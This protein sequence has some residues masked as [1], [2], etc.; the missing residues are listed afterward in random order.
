[1]FN[2]RYTPL[3]FALLIITLLCA[4]PTA[5]AQSLPVD[6]NWAS[7]PRKQIDLGTL[8]VNQTIENIVLDATGG[9]APYTWSHF[10]GS[11]PAGLNLSS[12]GVISGTPTVTPWSKVASFRIADALG[13]SVDVNFV[14][15]VALVEKPAIYPPGSGTTRVGIFYSKQ[16]QVISGK[17]PYTWSTTATLPAGLTLNATTGLLSVT[18]DSSSVNSTA[19]FRDYNIPI[20][21]TT[22]SN[23]TTT[24]N[25][26]LTVT[27][28][29]EWVTP[30]NLPVQYGPGSGQASGPNCTINLLVSGGKT[31]P[32][33]FRFQASS[34][35][36]GLTL[37]S[38]TGVLAGRPTANGNYSFTVNST[39]ALGS[40]IVRNFALEIIPYTL[41]ISGPQTG[42]GTQYT[43]VAP[44]Q[45]SA[46]GGTA[47]YKYS[48]TSLPPGLSINATT[49][50]ITGSMNGTSGTSNFTVTVT[51]NKS[52]TASVSCVFTVN[53][54]TPL[55]WE[56]DSPL[57]AGQVG[58]LYSTDLPAATGG[59]PAYTY[60]A[61]GLPGGLTFNATT[62]R[63]SGNP[64]VAG[65]FSVNFTVTDNAT[66]KNS[67]TRTIPLTIAPYMTVSGPATATGQQ[68]ISLTPVDFNVDGGNGNY[69]WS[70]VPTPIVPASLTINASTGIISGNLTA[71]PGNYSVRVL[72][73][74]ST[75]RNATA[76]ITITV[77]PRPPLEWVTPVKLPSGKVMDAYSENLSVSGGQ[78]AYKF[79]LKAGSTLPA[80]LV[81]NN[82]TG[83]LTG[84]PTTPGN[85]TFTVNASDS[86]NPVF[87]AERTFEISIA[88]YGMSISGPDSITGAQYSAISPATFTPVGGVAAYSWNATWS[89]NSTALTIN[90]AAG[91]V[92]GN[93]TT[94]TGATTATPGNYTMV[95]KLTD[96]QNQSITKNVTVRIQPLII[97]WVTPT[98]LPDGKELDNYSQTLEVEDGKAPYT[99]SLKTGSTLPAGIS[100]NGTTGV[101]SGKPTADGNYTFTIIAKDSSIPAN[102]S[103]QTF[104]LKV[105]PYGMAI[106]GATSASGQQYTA[107]T[108]VDLNVSGGSE[109]FTWTTA[110]AL[111]ATLTI[112]ASTGIISGNLTAIPGNTTVVVKV[113]DA[114]SRNATANF[115]V[116]IEQRELLVWVTPEELPG[117]KELDSYSE[118]LE[119]EGGKESYKFALKTGST[120]PSGITLNGT[121]GL[122]SGK[123]TADG[124]YS[125][126]IVASDSGNPVMTA[127]RT[128]T[129]KV[130]PY[131]MEI[132]GPAT[133]SGKQYTAL[134]PADFEVSGGAAP[135]T[136]SATPALP[137]GLTMNTTTGLVSGNLTAVPGNY[138]V[139]IKVSDAN[140]RNATANFTVTI[141][142]RPPVVWV[143]PEEL[144]DGKELDNYSQILEVEGGKSPYTFALKTG[145]AL[146]S[147]LTL[148]ATTGLL[149]G[150][151]TVANDYTFTIVASDTGNPVMTAECTFTLEVAPYGMAITGSANASGQQYTALTPA[152]FEVTG[153]TAPFTWSVTP[154]L[155][156]ALSIN[157]S[158]GIV[159]GNL[160]AV[161]GDYPVTIKVSDAN[162]RN[163]TANFIVTITPRDPVVW[164]TPEALPDGKEL[165]AYSQILE[166]EGGKSPYTFALKTGS[167]LPSGLTLNATTGLLSGKPTVAN[168]YTFTIIATDS[169]NPV[170]KEERTFT[171]YITP[172][173][174]EITGPATASGKQYTALTPADLN[175][176]GGT[177]PFTWSTAPAL[178]A[179]L[180]INSSTGIISGNLTAAPGNTTVVV[181]VSDAKSRN[182]TAN[183]TVTITQRDPV[184]WGTPEALP[185]GKELDA[186]SQNLT[187]SGGLAPYKFTLQSGT[188]PGGLTLNA[189]TG[190]LAGTASATSEGNYT[191]TINA[192]DSGN[193]VMSQIR[194]F[195]L[196]IAPYGLSVN[197]SA[198]ISGEQFIAISATTYSATGG[199][200]PYKWSATG[201]PA[202]LSINATTGAVSGN[203]TA[204][205]GNYTAN[206]TVTDNKSQTAS[207]PVVVS[208]LPSQLEWQTPATLPNGKVSFAY[209]QN[210]SVTQGKP[211]YTYVLANGSSL[212][213]GLALNSSTGVI[214]GRP[215]TAGTSNF[216]ITA[217][218]SGTPKNTADRTFSLT[219]DP[220][221]ALVWTINPAPAS[222][223][224]AFA[225]SANLSVASG[226]S[227]NYSYSANASTLPPGLSFNATTRRISGT[228]TASGTFNVSLTVRD[229]FGNA[230]ASATLANSTIQTIPITIEAYGL[231][232]N[233]TDSIVG[234]RYTSI[235]PATFAPVGG[236]A[237]Y[238]WSSNNTTGLTI[239]AT[240]GILSGNLTAEPGNYTLV[241]GLRDGRNQTATKNVAVQIRVNGLTWVTQPPLPAGKVA[242]PYTTN[243]T[244]SGGKPTYTYV[245]K[246]GS[247]LPIGL[248]LNNSTGIISGTP[249]S[250]TVGANASA[251]VVTTLAGSGNAGLTDG[252]GVGASFNRPGSV[253]I[254]ST[255]NLYVTD[256]LNHKIRK[257]SPDGIVTTFA[258]S[259]NAASADGTGTGA[260]FNGPTGIAI[261]SFGNLYISDYQGHKIRK[262]TP[263]GVVT[264]LAG[265]GSVGS[266]DGT[267]LAAS[268]NNPNA[269]AVDNIGNVYVSANNKIR[270]VTPNGVVTTLAGSGSNGSADGIGSAATFN[271]PSGVAVDSAGNVY[272]GD[273]SNNKIRK[274]S[275]A[276]VVTTLAGSGIGGSGDGTGTG[277]S[278]F[279]PYGLA[280]DVSGNIFV[281]DQGNSKIRKITPEGVVTTVAGSGTAGSL[282]GLG[283]N[284]TFNSAN[285]GALDRSGSMYVAEYWG[286]KIRK[287]SPA[288]TFTV[289]ASDSASPT[290]QTAERE[291]TLPIAPYGMSVNGT[292]TISGLQYSA[293][294]P[295]TFNAI[296][297]NATYTW[298]ANSTTPLGLSI[299]ATTGVV[300]GNL[301]AS[302]GNY[303]M[304][305]SVSDGLNQKASANVTVSVLKLPFDWVTQP[306]LP[307][308]QVASAYSANLSVSG[309]RPP[310][311]FVLANG[312]TLP[313]GLS[314]N[315]TTG[316]LTGAPT[317][318]GNYTFTVNASD[319]AV[320]KSTANRTF[321][322]RVLAYPM[323]LTGPDSITGQKFV[324]ITPVS[325]IAANGNG[326]YRWSINSTTGL[327]INATTGIVS[328]TPTVVAGNYSANITVTDNRTQSVTKTVSVIIQPVPALV[329]STT[330]P[331]PPGQVAFAYTTNLTVGG[332]RPGYTYVLSNGT[333]PTG[334]TLNNS[335]GVLS[336]TP[337]QAG[338]AN[339]TITASDSDAPTKNTAS[340][341]FALTIAPYGMTI[342]GSDVISGQQYSTISPTPYIALNGTANYTWSANNTIGLTINRTT[343]MVS[344]NLNASPGNYT[345][346]VSVVDGRNQ[347]ATK[348][349]TVSIGQAPA[350]AWVTQ[351]G[352]PS[353][354]VA[355]DYPLTFAGTGGRSPYTYILKAGSALPLGLSLNSTTGNLTGKPATA[356][357]SNFTLTLRDAANG[358]VDRTFSIEIEPYGMG[359]LGASPIPGKLHQFFEYLFGVEGGRPSYTWNATG[360]PAGLTMNATSGV[361][362]GT[363]SVSS[364]FTTVVRVTDGGN[365]SI[366]RTF[367][368]N[369]SASNALSI[370]SGPNFGPVSI[371]STYTTT[372][373]GLGGRPSYTWS[374]VGT[375]PASVNLATTGVLTANSTA[376]LT[377]N[378]T[379]RMQDTLGA[380]TTK[381]MS[382]VFFNPATLVI[383]TDALYTGWVGEEYSVQLG[384]LGGTQPYDWAIT[385]GTLPAGMSLSE[386]GYIYGTPTA[387]ANATLTLRVT[388]AKGLTANKTLGL[389]IQGK[390][391]QVAASGKLFTDVTN[392]ATLS[393]PEHYII[394]VEDF[395]NDGREDL[396]ATNSASNVVLMRG[397]GAF[398]FRDITASAG[399]NGINPA[400]V[401]DFNNDG[402][403]DI[404]SVNLQ[405]TEAVLFLNNGQGVFTRQVLTGLLTGD[406]ANYRDISYA[407]VDGDGDLDLLF[408]INAT[409]GGGVVAVFNQSNVSQT[410]SPLFNGK[411]YLV[412]TTWR[413]PKFSV[414]DA[415][416]DGKQDLVVVQTN[417]AWPNDTHRPQRASLYLNTGNTTADYAN[418]TGAKTRAG[419][420]EKLNSGITASSEMS[421]FT[422]FDIDNDGDL[423]LLNGSSDWPWSGSIPRIYINDGTGTYTQQDSPILHGRFYH[424]GATV[425][426][427]DLDGDQ[428]AV[429]SALHVF[430]DVYPRMWENGATYLKSVGNGTLNPAKAFFDS[431]TAWGIDAK[432]SGSGNMGS[433]GYA[434]DLDADG[435]LDYIANLWSSSRTY[436][437]Y[438]NDSNLRSANWLK[439]ELIGAVSP[440]QGTGARVEV[441]LSNATITR[442]ALSAS[443][444]S[445]EIVLGTFTWHQAKL[446]AEKRGG[447][448]VTISSEQEWND[449]KAVLDAR[450]TANSYWGGASDEAQN[451]TWKWIDG[452]SMT[453]TKWAAGEPNEYYG[454]ASENHL[455]IYSNGLWNDL[456][457]Q[458]YRPAGYICEYERPASTTANSK[459]AQYLGPETGAIS[460]SSLTFGLADKSQAAKVTVH[461]PSGLRSILENVAG[462]RTIQIYEADEL[463]LPRS[464]DEGDVIA[465][466]ANPNGETT[467][468]AFPAKAV[469]IVAGDSSSA[470]LLANGTVSVWGTNWAAQRNVP[471]TL[472]NVVQIAAGNNHYLALTANGSVVGWGWNTANQTIVPTTLRRAKSVAA[473]F[474]TSYAV[475]GGGQ[476]V[477][478]GGNDVGQ[479]NVPAGLVGVTS[480]AAGRGHALV[481]KSDGTVVAWGRN[482]FGQ[483][484]VPA[485]LT[486][487]VQIAAGDYH[488]VALKSNGT[489]VAWGANWSA[490]STAPVGLANVVQISAKGDRSMALK[491]DNSIVNWGINPNN[492][493]PP[494]SPG[495]ILSTAAGSKH[496][497]GLVRKIQIAISSDLPNGTEGQMISETTFSATGGNGTYTWSTLGTLPPGMTLNAATGKLSGTPTIAGTYTFTVRVSSGGRFSDIPVTI[498]VQKAIRTT[499]WV[500][501]TGN[502]TTGNGTISKPYATI[503]KAHSLA[504]KGDVIKVLPG[505]YTQSVVIEKAVE[506]S[507]TA[508]PS[509]TVLRSASKASAIFFRGAGIHGGSLSGFTLTGG[510]G[511]NN[512]GYNRYGGGFAINAP[513]GTTY[514][515]KNCIIRNNTD[516]GIT[517]GG[518]FH[519]TGGSTLKLTNSLVH[520]NAAWA[521]GG[522]ALI[523]GAN[524]IADR[525]T[526]VS[527]TNNG[528][529]RIGGISGAGNCNIQ[530]KN[531][532]LWNNSTNQYGSFSSGPGGNATFTF[533]YSI[534]QGGTTATVGGNTKTLVNTGTGCLTSDPVFAETTN[535]TLGAGS[536]A[537]N[538]GD[539]NATKDADG[540]RADMGW[541]PL[542]ANFGQFSFRDSIYMIV[543]GPTWEAAEA[544][545]VNLGGHLVTINDAE[546][547][548]FIKT[549][550][551]DKIPRSEEG[552]Y[553]GWRI[554]V[555]G[556]TWGWISNEVASFTNWAS[557]CPNGNSL[558][559]YAII[560]I[561]G[562]WDDWTNQAGPVRRGIAEIKLN[563]LILVQ[564]GTLPAGSALAGQTVSAFHIARLETTW[565]EWK[566]VRT[567]AIANGYDIGGSG[568]ALGDSHPVHSMTWQQILKWL[569]AKSEMEGLVPV[570]RIGGSVYKTGL[571][572]PT[573]L[574]GANGYRLPIEA[575]WEWA[576]RGGVFSQGFTYSGSNNLEEVAWYQANNTPQGTKAVGLKKPN[577]LGLYD[578][579]GNCWEY[580]WD[581]VTVGK[582]RI[583]GGGCWDTPGLMAYRWDADT[584]QPWVNFGFRYVRNAIGDMITVQG[585]T[586][587]SGSTLAGQ[588]VQTFVISRTEVTWGEWKEVRAWA[589]LN[590]YSDLANVGAGS[591]DNFPVTN[592]NWYDVVKW[593]NAKSQMCGLTPVYTVNGT[594]Y[595]TGQVVP[596]QSALAN[597]YRLPSE[598]EW[599]W[600]ARGGINTKGFSYSGSNDVNAAWYGS[601]AAEGTKAIGTKGANELGIYDMSGNVWEWCEDLINS[602]E[603]RRRGGGWIG[604]AGLTV[605]DRGYGSDPN[606]R[607]GDWGLRLARNAPD[608]IAA[609]HFL[610]QTDTLRISG[611]SVLNESVTI[612]AIVK[613]DQTQLAGSDPKQ[614]IHN[615]Y[616]EDWVGQGSMGQKNFGV[617][618][619]GIMGFVAPNYLGGA[620]TQKVMAISKDEWHHA[621]YV[622]D[623]NSERLYLDGA[624][625]VT[626]PS[627]NQN[628][629]ETTT[630]CFLGY[631]WLGYIS[632]F[633][634]SNVARY[635]GNSYSIPD[636]KL[637][638]DNSTLLLFNFTSINGTTV[639]DESGNGRNGT[640]GGSTPRAVNA[641]APVIVQIP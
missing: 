238:I 399:L 451:G 115:T 338:T 326:T 358:T 494:P 157:A 572:I 470:A 177:A 482:D 205:P 72:V 447:H 45:Y 544:N 562:K 273:M 31:P 88:E 456:P 248:T 344:G 472:N 6:V 471:T 427:A 306:S 597:G 386:T 610:N 425:F 128:F 414:T 19:N 382:V 443:G 448:L 573:I 557:G 185:S 55:A 155:P 391:G 8:A 353:A 315:A 330:S 376:A 401:A 184:V 203:L 187:A 174:M 122:L 388:D 633:R 164:S 24:A 434:A 47:P 483:S 275:S 208:I 42:N 35:P 48:T 186:Y 279:S 312:S 165:A 365:Q 541:D 139:A 22:G 339:F 234:D 295:T 440:A 497:L 130:L 598:K 256:I 371:N 455:H 423:D 154:P 613:F 70:T 604:S 567:W 632:S 282:D 465:W 156:T 412:K 366:T 159:S 583:R 20:K 487:V 592:V 231:S 593:C 354:R 148:N 476:V 587:P 221:D 394:A 316:A 383:A 584:S 111:P 599:E 265:S 525:C 108:P 202:T 479:A 446:D 370:V 226:G 96:G 328:G 66:P 271:N 408:N 496:A 95:I 384:A 473:G 607:F 626:R 621:A 523:E 308:G 410:A 539:P 457:G 372:L 293:I 41:T 305:V 594:T 614:P 67:I 350:L 242:S 585:G 201:L 241:V 346:P 126:T 255:G 99:F 246:N 436:K 249:T 543:E 608:Q 161:P 4:I 364:N 538:T 491:A 289:I 545:A 183:F 243:L 32:Y 400:L 81:L 337:G 336:G 469:Q 91:I 253:A 570:Y 73:R 292:S 379:V 26:T 71:A 214:N 197:G 142:S 9:Q 57:P 75:S 117:G 530:I 311:G 254:D 324:P 286:H 332:G 294:T 464:T 213:S 230:T 1:M 98:A 627:Q 439:V 634:V 355:L 616:L 175:V 551:L 216:T 65:N 513:A 129:L 618:T 452:S 510:G 571:I 30:S 46:I 223:K 215:T 140:T 397:V 378:F 94:G 563:K 209:T 520:S 605:A 146:P 459:V 59:W 264:T 362:S 123:P 260:S 475:T 547:N 191:F 200:A 535:Y 113:T 251:Y 345:L 163:A 609:L 519:V 101:L 236:N 258:G 92:S 415:N 68:Y 280:V 342:N 63:V 591:G 167:A 417:G 277:A 623:S 559:K 37:N 25:F 536:P 79:A 106:T 176:T 582:R 240:S 188:L 224:V 596:N 153:G 5:M 62:R 135:F 602:T 363:P 34:P 555:V 504:N 228:P 589:L 611:S 356:G 10:D 579:S 194:T 124:D 516:S 431:T 290:K 85:F 620:M 542:T 395:D 398:D 404:L 87:S 606:D 640:L 74:D 532:I 467:V 521:N 284:A 580:C 630:S 15:T 104:T 268:F 450:G 526:I 40:V 217:S 84:K 56:I 569:N 461:W 619:S 377:A 463:P 529:N 615:I 310:Y 97:A 550:I 300:S 64:T 639:F 549:E 112:N 82:S 638:S 309:G 352:L 2:P 331:L 12:N 462:N 349:V 393:L 351:Q 259:G 69:T 257:I 143:T 283:S 11:M 430:S 278:F 222:G 514:E 136:W 566:D 486:N 359:I 118:I 239:N 437:V 540:S 127:E 116:T 564:G 245:L 313:T 28:P 199:A 419:F 27:K 488:S 429:W 158:T 458:D 151:P 287:I 190:R 235:T 60:S 460:E 133:A 522:A 590:G 21:L 617:T 172:Y 485:G 637:S 307:D 468:P 179:S 211:P 422:S 261:D 453:F 515:V 340:R 527:N 374:I 44:L 325:Y 554:P 18:P 297:G 36:P 444:S 601:N 147:G 220:M 586:L 247:T 80:G 500:S 552:M 281:A 218:D 166:V 442:P 489:V 272:V 505:T 528:F 33:N 600:A 189:T 150:K 390:P 54:G 109:P 493:N 131:G 89:G 360:V 102:Q 210:L 318:A 171:L 77:Q 192:S 13:K 477:A 501:T 162:S 492:S 603:R 327:T 17:K 212:P 574:P 533:S 534:V 612:E 114:N 182:A 502:D 323:T 517:F 319:S 405:R 262:I 432:I 406:L 38:T 588:Q 495:E 103:E 119:V 509:Q 624:L 466:G 368:I 303:T 445:Y 416:G 389:T 314:L 560:G 52:M 568:N 511:A 83:A 274:I 267:G 233:G 168:D 263:S 302:P 145:S 219:I 361:L 180:S 449:V 636:R 512:P 125:F 576:S 631:G 321:T 198:T 16:F 335:T 474:N 409:T 385:S 508:G 100:L 507:S 204:A 120:L 317:T 93:L 132:T 138:T 207:M 51:D 288:N 144:P 426:D 622:M 269:V 556:N 43:A 577:E 625:V 347:T 454:P 420:T 428:D 329:W 578:M 367:N 565:A 373:Q 595:K 481:L 3:F 23:A 411:S 343:G 503:G 402:V 484:T 237:T 181:K 480:L 105:L 524:L 381:A 635:T 107:L 196:T 506:I 575:E 78:P 369:I 413:N 276:G 39:D 110:P 301:T 498:V 403:S 553:I 14:L 387:S 380:N 333:L 229:N 322:L 86:G 421:A 304:V 53:P 170:M 160:T 266:A 50:L 546:E 561:G 178:P 581:L 375:K 548:A 149:S 173:G 152:D 357:T 193:P 137:A 141:T 433:A 424:H 392:A 407:D 518:G 490:Q 7:S 76:N 49:G 195:T 134:T 227:G 206:I 558:E 250:A 58:S 225:Y 478:W 341:P 29:F 628:I 531:S 348:N 270:K 244:V 285:L 438:R 90:S 299:N 320:P 537:I 291:F 169:G 441:E 641:T 232:I 334:L 252:T 435:D 298:S 121:T 499:L 629:W 396:L 296:G 61:S 418:P